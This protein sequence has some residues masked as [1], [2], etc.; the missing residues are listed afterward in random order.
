MQIKE[1]ISKLQEFDENLE[2]GYYDFDRV[3]VVDIVSIEKVTDTT[4]FEKDF[5]SDLFFL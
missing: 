2:I 1:L 3:E 4:K 5:K